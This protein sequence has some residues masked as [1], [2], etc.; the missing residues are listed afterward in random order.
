MKNIRLI[1]INTTAFKEENF[2]LVT[3]LTHKQIKDVIKPI[4]LKERNN[5]IFYD[6][7]TLCEALR[8]AYPKSILLDYAINNADRIT[9]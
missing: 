1:E 7:N 3:N 2:L 9:I 8:E 6:N 4:V 5:D